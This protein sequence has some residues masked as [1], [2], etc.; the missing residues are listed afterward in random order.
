LQ[1]GLKP[2]N[3]L[4]GITGKFKALVGFHVPGSYLQLL[5]ISPEIIGRHQL[6]LLAIASPVQPLSIPEM[7][8]GERTKVRP[9]ACR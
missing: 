8:T 5:K 2:E 3:L 4:I 7:K 6:G 9:P 1:Q